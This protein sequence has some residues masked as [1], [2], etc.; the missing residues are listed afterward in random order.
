V[1]VEDFSQKLGSEQSSGGNN[2]ALGISGWRRGNDE[3][4]AKKTMAIALL[5]GKFTV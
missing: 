2:Q 5:Y 4:H 1:I 3:V